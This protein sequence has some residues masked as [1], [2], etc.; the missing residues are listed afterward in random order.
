M[1]FDLFDHMSFATVETYDKKC[2]F[3]V[4]ESQNFLDVFCQMFDQTFGQVFDQVLDQGL[5][6]GK[7][8]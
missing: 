1:L 3:L 6:R 7:T 5:G 2:H 4:R 8:A